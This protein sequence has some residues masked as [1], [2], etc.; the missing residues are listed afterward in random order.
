MN[1]MDISSMHWKDIMFRLYSQPRRI[2][3]NLLSCALE[4]SFLL[5]LR[6]K[7]RKVLGVATFLLTR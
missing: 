1:Y 3:N 4:A 5:G 6:E 7:L 2:V